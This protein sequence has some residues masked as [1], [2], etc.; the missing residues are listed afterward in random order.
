MNF[1][2]TS[3]QQDILGMIKDFCLKEVKPNAAET[4][5]EEKFPAETVKKLQ[6][7]GMM[8][9]Y[10]PEE[11]GGAGLDYLTY[12]LTCEEFA[13]YCATTSVMFSGHSSLCCWPLLTCGTEEQKQKYL[14]PLASGKK[15]G[16]FGL[17]EPS[18]GTDAAMQKSFAEKQ[19]DGS[20]ILN[21]SKTFITNAGY[22]DTY[23]VFAMTEKGIGTK[24]ISAFILEKGMP[25]FTVGKKEKK[26]GIRGSSTCDLIFENVHIPAENLLGKEGKGFAMAMQTLDGG[27][28]GIA[29]Q[30]IGIAEGAIEETVK[31]VSER[32]QFGKRTASSR[33]RSSSLRTCR[34]RW[35]RDVF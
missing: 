29:A 12:I 28:I 3:E 4:D 24:G 27:R 6:D 8:G 9:M 2:L 35:K 11:Y 32:M 7:M 10:I 13:K 19:A 33:T 5:E 30:A 14:V 17:T 31:Y 26:M 22:A 15:L 18:A 1:G 16:A 20:Y 25:G 23:I 21:G 34:R